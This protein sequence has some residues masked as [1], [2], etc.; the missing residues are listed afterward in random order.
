[1]R[2]G[3][4][5]LFLLP[6]LVLF[7][8]TVFADIPIN[9]RVSLDGTIRMRAFYDERDFD[10]ENTDAAYYGTMRTMIG[11]KIQATDDILFRVKLKDSRYM[12]VPLTQTTPGDY[13]ATI[14]NTQNSSSLNLQEGYIFAN[15]LFGSKIDLQLGRFEMDYGRGR[16]M[17]VG[18]WNVEGPHAYDGFRLMWHRPGFQFDVFYSILRDYSFGSVWPSFRLPNTYASGVYQFD[19]NTGYVEMKRYLGGIAASFADGAIQPMLLFDFDSYETGHDNSRA[20]QL[21]SDSKEPQFW[22]TPAIYTQ[23]TLSEDGGNRWEFEADVAGQFGQTNDYGAHPGSYNL[24]SFL[25]A[26]EIRLHANDDTKAFVGVGFDVTGRGEGDEDPRDVYTFYQFFYTQHKFRGFMDYFYNVPNGLIDGYATAGACPTDWLSLRVDAH[27]FTYLTSQGRLRRNGSMEELNQ[28]GQEVDILAS[29]EI[30]KGF[31]LDAG[32][33]MFIP[34]YEFATR[35][36]GT[37]AI[38]VPNV[39]E[40]FS[41]Y[42]YVVFT[43]KF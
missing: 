7:A 5:R 34:S 27:N 20:Q 22:I 24:L 9:E 39:A 2:L 19:P 35:V 14:T 11:F 21:V 15:D 38:G 37:A 12:G 23:F 29:F 40:S 13:N 33:S 6:V 31:Y 30:K 17:G 32:Y 43:T 8:T 1:M 10:T 18:G 25:A 28:L 42:A 36:N 3:K 4:G 41:H 26:L 16:I